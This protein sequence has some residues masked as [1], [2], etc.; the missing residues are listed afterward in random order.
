MASDTV[1]NLEEP[2]LWEAEVVR[3]R[4]S[5]EK[6]SCWS[7]DSNAD[8][9]SGVETEVQQEL[10]TIGIPDNLGEP[11]LSGRICE[12][13][14]LELNKC[15][16]VPLGRPLPLPLGGGRGGGGVSHLVGRMAR[17]KDSPEALLK[18]AEE[19][20]ALETWKQEGQA[21]PSSLE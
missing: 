3:S 5:V 9:W 13:Q 16:L 18:K 20:G 11:K 6:P 4:G 17:V 12:L 15:D 14:A 8:S 19:L 21:G 10:D 1:G 7:S 2:K